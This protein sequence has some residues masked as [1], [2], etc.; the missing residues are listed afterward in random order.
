MSLKGCTGRSVNVDGMPLPST[1]ILSA[2]IWTLVPASSWVLVIYHF[3][4]CLF[5]N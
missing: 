5:D 1:R 2:D 4:T 3:G